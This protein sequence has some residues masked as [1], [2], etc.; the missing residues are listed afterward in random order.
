LEIGDQ[1]AAENLPPPRFVLDLCGKTQT[2]SDYAYAMR[3]PKWRIRMLTLVDY[4]QL[5]VA[6]IS[7]V[8]LI[9]ML[10]QNEKS[11]LV[12]VWAVF[13]AGLASGMIVD[14]FGPELG[15]ARHV[16]AIVGSGTCGVSW[17]VARCLFRPNDRFNPQHLW[18]I[19]A[20]MGPSLIIHS[21]LFADIPTLMG[22]ES[23]AVLRAGLGNFQLL[24][25]STA[26]VLA[27][28]EGLRGWTPELATDERRL[29]SLYLVTYG[30]CVSV[31]TVW[32]GSDVAGAIGIE[33]RSVQAVAA[34][35]IILA[36]SVAM[37]YRMRHPLPVDEVKV[38][39]VKTRQAPTADEVE[40]AGRLE[41]LLRD[42]RPYLEPELKVSVLA[43]RLREPDYKISRAITGV[44]GYR[45][46]NQLINHHRVEHAKML[47]KSEP[48]CSILAVGLDSG[49]ASIGPF[50]RAFK[51]AE[52]M[53]PRAFRASGGA[54]LG[55]GGLAAAE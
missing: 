52:G 51:G 48:D 13:N 7:I 23:F 39:A 53:T 1:V 36:L 37:A 8:W 54:G 24:A 15:D 38:G 5:S 47:L 34:I 55:S 25:S 17:L 33:A 46:F 4:I 22:A 26:L 19:G 44:L 6:A 12:T 27:F 28:W 32:S 30:L 9:S 29:R 43:R 18:L 45:N 3:R 2:G 14:V 31:T 11:T 16:F 41:R 40:L 50:N 21:M 20:I 10:S 35:V 42:E 49:F